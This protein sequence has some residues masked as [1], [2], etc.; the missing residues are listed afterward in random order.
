MTILVTGATG[1][2]GRHLV[3]HLLESGHKVRALTRD[4]ARA[5]LP[6]GVEVVAGDLTDAAGLAPVL[7]GVTAAHLINFAGDYRPLWNGP[8]I[9]AAAARAGVTRVTMLGGWQEGTLEPAVQASALEWTK[10]KPVEFMGNTLADWAG[11][12]RARG[13]V[14]EPYGERRSAPV[15]ESDIAAVAAAALTEEGH[16]GHTYLIT[17]PEVLTPRDKIRILAEATGQDLRLEE[18]T[19]EQT[20]AEWIERG[21]PPEMLL[22]K[23]F[24]DDPAI[25]DGEKVEFLLKV[26]GAAHKAGSTVSGVVEAVTGRPGRTFAQWAAEHADAFRP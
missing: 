8:E 9:A 3:R 2:V 18:L 10:L 20:R 23:V 22:F 19:P 12:L 11:R 1:T 25:G 7:D 16:A 6:Q 14:R 4:P 17:G 15:H 21:R 13:V 24:G 26:Y 5:A